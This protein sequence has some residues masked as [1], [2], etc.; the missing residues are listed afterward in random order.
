MFSTAVDESKARY[1]TV[2]ILLFSTGSAVNT[3][4]SPS[5]NSVVSAINPD[6]PATRLKASV[7]VVSSTSITLCEVP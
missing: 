6:V 5:R 3:T 2:K 7:V 1:L 4:L